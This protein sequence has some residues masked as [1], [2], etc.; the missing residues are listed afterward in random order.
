MA[1]NLDKHLPKKSVKVSY[2]DNDGKRV[3]N[4]TQEQAKQVEALHGSLG[5][6]RI[7]VKSNF[8]GRDRLLVN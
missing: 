1:L 6:L 2:F 5:T 8:K 4:I 7:I 3:D